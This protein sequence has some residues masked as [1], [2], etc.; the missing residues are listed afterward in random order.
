[1]I[2][3]A[4]VEI[5]ETVHTYNVIVNETDVDNDSPKINVEQW[6]PLPEQPVTEFY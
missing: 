2:N 5:C 4:S 1:M 3:S 6:K